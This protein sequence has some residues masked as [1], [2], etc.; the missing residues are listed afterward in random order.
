[1]ARV[2]CFVN[3]R[4]YTGFKPLRVVDSLVAGYGR[5]LYT[6]EA[7]RAL[8]LCNML[9]GEVVDLGGRVVLPG[10]IDSHMHLDGLGLM[11]SS[12]ELR[13]VSSIRE[14]KERLGKYAREASTGWIYGRGWDQELFQEARWPTRWDL[15]E[16]VSDRPV[17][18]VRVCGH[19]GVL[20]TRAM[21]AT[22]LINSSLPGVLR[23]SMGEATG[24][25]VE[26][27]LEEA[28]RAYHSSLATSDRVL[29]LKKALEYA[30]SMGVTSV[31]FMSCSMEYLKALQELARDGWRYPR[32]RIYV[33][34]GLFRRIV[35]QGLHGLLGDEYIRIQGVKA[36]ADGSLGAR[37]AWLSKPYSDDPSTTGRQLVGREE[38]TWIVREASRIGLQ[39][40]VHS[41]GDAALDLVLSVYREFPETS[42]LRHRIEHASLIRPDQVEEARRIGVAI[43]V[44]P[45]FVISDWWAKER[46]GSERVRWLY[47]FKTLIESNIWLGISTDSPVEPL[48][49]WETVYAAVT[50]GRL[51]G[52]PFY[53]DTRHEALDAWEALYYYTMGSAYIMHMEDY[54]G[55]LDEGKYADFI[56]VDRDPFETPV[57][58]LNRI[59]VLETYVGGEKIYGEGEPG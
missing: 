16:V 12:L 19:A 37:T 31:G 26:E 9:G 28:L 41:I 51:E 17:I 48:N 23:N 45:R 52:N 10:F 4:V 11:L 53:E 59:K 8:S 47:P 20:N 18:L 32:V 30:A 40:A 25:V 38:L 55:S 3:A 58:E 22:G 44:Q 15:D 35:E 50:R 29:F 39:V 34:T 57:E 46:L 21:E 49:P 5:I 7:G 2:K 42:I 24:V 33:D 36:F 43:S 56:V 14:L 13:G 1:L 54:A 6:G 27:A